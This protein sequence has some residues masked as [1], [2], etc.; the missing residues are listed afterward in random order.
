MALL[1]AGSIGASVWYANSP[2]VMPNGGDKA[3]QVLRIVRIN[4]ATGD[5]NGFGI[6]LYMAV[7][8]QLI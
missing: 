4:I 1:V 5:A 2:V 8:R 7:H 3:G 6:Q